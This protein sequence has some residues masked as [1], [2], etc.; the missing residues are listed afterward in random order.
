MKRLFLIALAVLISASAFAETENNAEAYNNRGLT[1]GRKGQ[2][3]QAIS[4]STKAIEL[5]PNF[6]EAY[7]NRGIA[8]YHKGEYDK[9]WDDIYKAQ[10]LGY[11]VH[12]E[13]LKALRAASG[14]QE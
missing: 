10:S 7:N 5:N 13:F 14:R 2:Y 3:D 11:Q 4:D 6:A 9:A 1:F 8:C 12:P